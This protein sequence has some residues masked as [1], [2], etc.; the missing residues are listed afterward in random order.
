MKKLLTFLFCTAIFTS[1]FAQSNRHKCDDRN[2]NNNHNWNS[3]NKNGYQ[4]DHDRDDNMIYNNNN[5]VYQN[6]NNRIYQRDELIKRINSQYDY[7][8]QQVIYDRSLN[9]RQKEYAIRSLQAQKAQQLDNIY[10]QY[11]NSNVYN[12][13]NNDYHQNG[14][15]G[16]GQYNR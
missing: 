1:A 6:N 16:Y 7:R 13:R 12:K 14:N 5:S 4:N 2:T 9:R 10:S 3:N 15:N 11:N 8:M